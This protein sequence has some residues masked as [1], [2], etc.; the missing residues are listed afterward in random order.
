MLTIMNEQRTIKVKRTYLELHD[1]PHHKL[2]PIENVQLV[3][4]QNPSLNFYRFLYDAVGSDLNWVDRKLL[5]DKQLEVILKSVG[6]KLFVMYQNGQPIGYAELEMSDPSDIEIAYFGLVPE[7][8][9]LGYGK[10]LLEWIIH[11]AADYSPDRIWLHTCELD[12][13]NAMQNY[14]KRGFKVYDQ[15]IVDQVI[16]A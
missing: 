6:F 4:C 9:G 2:Q 12:H 5:S 13:P 15:K 16:M 1:Y 8:R 7:F 3:R 11:H 10:Y 14:L